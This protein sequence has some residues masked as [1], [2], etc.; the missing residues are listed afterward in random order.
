ML[1]PF[2]RFL[3]KWF[4]V[5]PVGTHRNALKRRR[6]S[7]RPRLEVLED[8][9]VPSG[10]QGLDSFLLTPVPDG[11]PIAEHIHPHL[12]ILINGQN[13]AIPA[14]IGVEA[15]GDLPLHTHDDSGTIHIESPAARDFTLQ[16][17]FTV[18][19][20]SFSSQN[21]LGHQVDAADPLV[22]TVNGQVSSAWGSL[23]L[24]DQ[25]NIVIQ[26]G[27]APAAAV[28]TDQ[29]SYAPGSTIAVSGTGFK[30]G[31]VVDLQI[32]HIDGTVNATPS[33]LQWTTTADA[34]GTI[35]AT[36]ITNPMASGAQVAGLRFELTASGETSHQAAFSTFGSQPAPVSTATVT[37][38]RFDYAPGATA[39]ISGSGFAA[40]EIVALQV[41]HVDGRPNTDASHTPWTVTADAAGTFRT[42]WTVDTVDAVQSKLDVHAVGVTSQDQADATFTDSTTP[43]PFWIFGHN[44]NTLAVTETYI[45]MGVNALEPDVEFFADKAKDSSGNDTVSKGFYIAHQ[46]DTSGIAPYS[47][48]SNPTLSVHDYLGQLSQ[49]LSNRKDANGNLIPNTQLS[50]I[51]LDVKTEATQAAGALA[52]L[53]S[54]ISTEILPQ[55]P[56]LYFLL[57]AGTIADAN[58]LFTSKADAVLKDVPLAS[59]SHF[60]FSIDGENDA[61]SVKQTLRT[62]LGPDALIAYGDGTSGCCDVYGDM[63]IVKNF[64][65]TTGVAA[66]ILADPELAAVDLAALIA[67]Q[68][69]Y[70]GPNVGPS[71][72]SAVAMRATS[73]AFNMIAYGFSIT[74]VD[75]M[76][77]LIDSGVD[78][79][80]PADSL[81]VTSPFSIYGFSAVIGGTAIGNKSFGDT[82]DALNLVKGGY[83]GTFMATT[84][85]DPFSTQGAQNGK[86]TGSRNGYSLEVKT[87]DVLGAGTDAHITF[88]LHGKNGDAAVTIDS[89][90]PGEMERNDTNYVFIPSADLG[91]LTS[92]T[93]SHD[94]SASIFSTSEWNLD[95]V[96]VRSLAYIGANAGDFYEA[97][98]GGQDI[99]AV[100][101]VSFGLL[102]SICTDTGDQNPSSRPLSLSA[103][104]SATS[105]AT[106]TGGVEGVTA[107]TL[108]AATFHDRYTANT[109][110][111]VTAV[112]WG[113]GSTDATGLTISG[114]NGD[115]TV[116]GS[117]LYT[118]DGNFAFSI[119]IKAG[120]TGPDANQTATIYGEVDVS[121][122]AVVL[123]PATFQATEGTLSPVE[124]L[125]TFTDPGGAEPL[126]DYAV[127]VDWGNGTFVTDANV[128]I[129]GSVNGVFTVT[130]QHLYADEDGYPGPVRVR[131]DHE[132]GRH[133]Q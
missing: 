80:I 105:L 83:G 30:A 48:Y 9:T 42:T 124:T 59:R 40:G 51:E 57:N 90:F 58:S 133:A 47:N 53:V 28:H 118:E 5:A 24:H 87:S 128:S 99:G 38:D 113:D 23:V 29:A 126:K 78:G 111:T 11:S 100:H 85:D 66:L 17:F 63:S 22:L 41:L 45:N 101:C 60:A 129:G 110:F 55:H 98:Y 2:R 64:L 92:I 73:G 103:Y 46:L 79:L 8:R 56:E 115:F 44:P 107:A 76:K 77:M 34:A 10:T 132:P 50:L 104:L 54:T 19:G 106:A 61:S 3:K 43:R 95:W 49:F 18:W 1:N 71:L 21:V 36:W 84:A 75:S 26:Y 112:N 7:F 74:G 114:S 86:A 70:A 108:S 131:I 109:N 39:V 27:S 67:G 82:R 25:D 37:T 65:G 102:G 81:D 122:P 88:T 20:Q 120:G 31:E 4:G 121:D 52:Y 117:H 13:Q 123:T 72:Q 68:F 125:A 12:S 91:D 116:N 130:G 6:P 32:T 96:K 93:V 16:D 94:G 127:A 15:D 97:D 119:T 33:E 69:I 35:S 62:L 14:D 89:N